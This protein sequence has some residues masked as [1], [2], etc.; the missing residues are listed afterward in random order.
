MPIVLPLV[1]PIELSI[2]FPSGLPLE[3]SL[4]LPMELLIQLLIEFEWLEDAFWTSFSSFP[5]PFGNL[6]DAFWM[7]LGCIFEPGTRMGAIF[8]NF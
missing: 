3:L 6:L 1:L 5:D 8:A 7:P 4:E 2:E